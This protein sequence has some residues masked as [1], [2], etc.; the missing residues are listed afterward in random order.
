MSI[1]AVA[2]K[3]TTVPYS[4]DAFLS[5]LTN[6]DLDASD[7]SLTLD[8]VGAEIKEKKP[9]TSVKTS[10]ISNKHGFSENVVKAIVAA[11]NKYSVD[12]QL[13]LDFAQIESSGRPGASNGKY[14][15]LFALDISKYGRGTFNAITNSN[16]AAAEIST[17][18]RDFVTANGRQPNG[19]EL[20]LLHQQGAAGGP[21]HMKNLDGVAWKN[22]SKFYKYESVAKK[23]IWNNIP[24]DMKYLFPGGVNTVT[25][26]E[27]Y[28]VW[29]SKLEKVPYE[30]A[31]AFYKI[32]VTPDILTANLVSNSKNDKAPD[33]FETVDVDITSTD[34]MPLSDSLSNVSSDITPRSV[35]VA[36]VEPRHDTHEAIVDQPLSADVQDK[37]DWI[38]NFNW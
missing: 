37:D 26:A 24:Q 12:P 21:A 20:Y 16:A 5:S 17:K 36:A 32:P 28:A 19:T 4:S 23:A 8:P 22:I 6:V 27:F 11:A 38:T 35:E 18:I 15:G 9:S 13:M 10:A 1:S 14:G 29:K 7:T 2:D 31:L 33:I 3:S 34:E 25:S 30:T